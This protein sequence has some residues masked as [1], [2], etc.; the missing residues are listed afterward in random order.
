MANTYKKT[1]EIERF[2]EAFKERHERYNWDLYAR[3]FINHP[4]YYR[5]RYK[6]GEGLLFDVYLRA[7]M[8]YHRTNVIEELWAN[9]RG[10]KISPI[11]NSSPS[12]SLRRGYSGKYHVFSSK[13]KEGG[14]LKGE[15]DSLVNIS[16]I[17]TLINFFYKEFPNVRNER[18]EIFRRIFG[19]DL[20]YGIITTKDNL[21]RRSRYFEKRRGV[22]VALQMGKEELKRVVRDVCDRYG[23][24]IKGDKGYRDF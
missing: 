4:D 18:A 15:C 16:G 21:G 17:P 14:L 12:Y 22:V 24:R 2:F 7:F 1:I 10:F 11:S 20:G 9:R 5:V 8:A 23:F 6:K 19:E 3:D 13:N